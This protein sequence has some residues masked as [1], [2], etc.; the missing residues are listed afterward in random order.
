MMAQGVQRMDQLFAQALAAG[1]LSRDPSLN[2][3][4]PPP[5][6]ELPA[7]QPVAEAGRPTSNAY[8]VQVT[9]NDVNIYNFAMAHL[10]DAG[11]R[12]LRDAAADQSE[13]A[14][15][16]FSSPISGD[17]SQLASALSARGWLV[18]IVR[19]RRPDSLPDRA[20]RRAL[21]PPPVASAA[22]SRR[23]AAP[24][25]HAAARPRRSE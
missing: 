12:R 21:P 24:P 5:M 2:Q 4:P 25:R 13:R 22:A 17:I 18:E 15:A 8:Q 9:G 19:D 7:E 11:R 1:P 23:P 20:S 14:R 6:P 16:T 3:P 10:A